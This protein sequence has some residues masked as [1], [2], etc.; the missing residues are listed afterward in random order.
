MAF[1]KAN[2]LQ[3]RTGKIRLGPLNLAQLQAMLAKTSKNKE[4]A[5]IQNR[6]NIV[7]AR[8]NK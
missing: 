7:E 3:T 5:K 8:I 2:P 1:K 6:I 4:K